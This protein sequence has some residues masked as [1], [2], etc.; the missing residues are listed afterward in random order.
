LILSAMM[1]TALLDLRLRRQRGKA[2]N[3]ADGGAVR[4]PRTQFMVD[5][6]SQVADFFW[7]NPRGFGLSFLFFFLG[8][9]AGA[10]ELLA[11][12]HALRFPLS[13]RD[14][15]AL[16]ALLASVNMATFFIPANAGSQE[17]G[18]T[19]LAPL[20]GISA[21]HAVALAVL[22]R[23]RDVIWVA[24]GLAYLGITEGRIL[25]RPAVDAPEPVA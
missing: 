17:G 19:Y 12:A 21:P 6:W 24:Y 18:F 13:V 14:A 11:A 8:W 15:L 22:R 7:T 25:F 2:G 1:V 9:A 4:K 10:L 16:E 23:C 20:W 5:L 3:G